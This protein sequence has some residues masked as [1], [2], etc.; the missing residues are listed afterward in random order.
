[1]PAPGF[2]TE[3]LVKGTQLIKLTD[4]NFQE[5][6]DKVECFPVK[7]IIFFLHILEDGNQEPF[8]AVV[9]VNDFFYPC[10]HW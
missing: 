8:I 2:Q 7:I 5:G 9:F 3:R 10:F 4:G 1:M 6:T